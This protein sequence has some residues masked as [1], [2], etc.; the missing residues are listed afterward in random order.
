MRGTEPAVPQGAAAK[1]G[2][3]EQQARALHSTEPAEKKRVHFDQIDGLFEELGIGK[4]LME[5]VG[6]IRV[7]QHVNPLKKDL[8]VPTQ[9]LR[10]EEVYDDPTLPLALDIGCGYGRFPLA[11]S[12]V[13]PTHNLLGLE[14]REQC[15][16]RAQ[17]WS[18]ALGFSGRVRFC[19]SNATVSLGTMLETYPGALDLVTIQFPDPHFK[20]KHRKRRVVQ[21]QLVAALASLVRP[22]GR[23]FL[24]SDVQE[25]AESM[26]NEFEEHGSD[27]FEL[28]SLHTP[29]AVFFSGTQLPQA[30]ASPVAWAALNG[31]AGTIAD[32]CE[33]ETMDTDQQTV[34]LAVE[35]QRKAATGT[36]VSVA[37][38]SS[39]GGG[40][41][42]SSSV[43]HAANPGSAVLS[44]EQGWQGA[45]TAKAA[46]ATEGTGE[47]AVRS[48]AVPSAAAA[49]GSSEG[50]PTEREVY[51]L[52]Q[53][54]PVFR[55]ML[56][57]K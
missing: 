6:G 7:R 23:V 51:T 54:L 41:S 37:H 21:P 47:A 12:R 11:L 10:W 1:S 4:G 53:G 32:S 40:N 44:E 5:Q 18:D 14:I 2:K 57:R 43:Q 33:E 16:E 48:A 35:Q 27:A 25:V 46:A 19:H 8:Q 28:A 24:Q 15:V 42:S 56:V 20:R 49:V 22:G 17:K 50:I 52:E 38:E 3:N 39:S 55:V 26:R 30:A 45:A 29:Q 31:R 13:L 36:A 34:T 9:P